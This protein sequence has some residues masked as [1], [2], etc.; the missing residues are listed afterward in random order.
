M[1]G[2]NQ[3]NLN[4]FSFEKNYPTPIVI[5]DTFGEGFQDMQSGLLYWSYFVDLAPENA[6]FNNDTK[7]LFLYYP[8]SRLQQLYLHK[9]SQNNNGFGQDTFINIRDEFGFINNVFGSNHFSNNQ[10]AYSGSKN[11]FNN[12]TFNDDNC[13]NGCTTDLE[14]RTALVINPDAAN[15]CYQ[16]VCNIDIDTLFVFATYCFSAANFLNGNI[17]KIKYLN[18]LQNTFF[19]KQITGRVEFLGIKPTII[20]T[21]QTDIFTTSNVVAIHLPSNVLPSNSLYT[22]IN[23]NTTNANKIIIRE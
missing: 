18:D 5:T 11:I 1:I 13:F 4:V 19:A 7:E 14:F 2:Y 8:Y 6:Y 16:S 22:R 21:P 3:I 23:S 9:S 15:F 10:P 12:I 17:L 20:T